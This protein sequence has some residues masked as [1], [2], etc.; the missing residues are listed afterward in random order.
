MNPT[1]S[2]STYCKISGKGLVV[3]GKPVMQNPDE[4]ISF[5]DFIKLIYKEFEFSYPKFF[6][7][8]N[9]CKLGFAAAEV[10]LR[11][12][13]IIGK[14]QENEIAVVIQN[15]SSSMDTDTDYLATIKNRENYFPSPALFVYTLAN[16]LIGEISIKNHLTG[17]NT[18]FVSEKPDFQFLKNYAESLLVSGAAKAC[19][20]GWVDFDRLSDDKND[21]QYEAFIY[22]VESKE[23]KLNFEHSKENI[24][25]FY[26]S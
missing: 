13:G 18:L 8:D 11:E 25:T 16:I 24:I 9:L 23:N 15:R 20:M 10:A 22:I 1:A 4:N 14:Y 6:K 3:N 7:M 2:I 5:P 26:Q 12:S 19:I 21:V 17:E